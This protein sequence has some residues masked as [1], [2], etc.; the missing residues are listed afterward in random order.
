VVASAGIVTFDCYGTLVDW[1][2]GISRAFQEEARGQG[3]ELAR[4]AILAAYARHEPEVQAAGFRPYRE[5]LARASARTAESLGWTIPSG[6]SN[7][8]AESLPTWPVFPDTNPA[9]E[10][11]RAAG[12]RLGI[13]SNIDDDLLAATRR[14]FSADFDLVVTAAQVRSY[15]P[16]SGHFLEA[17]RRIGGLR[18]LHAAQSYF[19]DV[20]PARALGIEVAWINRKGERPP[21]GG[22]PDR[23]FPDLGAL[24]RAETD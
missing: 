11:L 10:R 7:F 18:W 15:K 12:R 3:I 5:V 6:R 19:H 4:E 13:L 1:E 14:G 9:L 20:A 22:R 8:L 2:A 24:A 16:A 17:R 21:D 23:E